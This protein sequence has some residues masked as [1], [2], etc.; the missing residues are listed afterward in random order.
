MK[1]KLANMTD[2]LPEETSKH[3]DHV[4]AH[5]IGASVLGYFVLDETL[6]IVL[7]TGFIWTVYVDGQMMLLPQLA[8]IMEFETDAENRTE[9]SREIELLMRDGRCAEGL[10]RVSPA[11]LECLISEVQFYTDQDRRLFVIIGE[12]SEL[13]IE[14]S[15]TTA[16]MQITLTERSQ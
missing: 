16:Q 2:W 7:D 3:Q 11:A 1:A 8:A 13:K 6:H 10:E 9:L 12:Q 14:T 5:V 4:I 15:L